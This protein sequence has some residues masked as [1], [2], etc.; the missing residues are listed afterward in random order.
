MTV[1][2]D[3][4][5]R[6]NDRREF[7]ASP[8]PP[9]DPT[10]PGVS[11]DLHKHVNDE[12]APWDTPPARNLHEIPLGRRVVVPPR[13]SVAIRA[14]ARR[15]AAAERGARG[16]V[17]TPIHSVNQPGPAT[18]E[19]AVDGLTAAPDG[20]RPGTG[21]ASRPG[22]DPGSGSRESGGSSTREPGREQVGSGP[23]ECGGEQPGSSGRE[24]PGS[25][26]REPGGSRTGS[27][28]GSGPREHSPTDD[29]GADERDQERRARAARATGY[30]VPC[31]VAGEIRPARYL[32]GDDP[33]CVS[34][35]N[36]RTRPPAA[37][38]APEPPFASNPTNPTP[39]DGRATAGA[40]KAA[41]S[42]RARA[43]QAGPTLSR[44]IKPPKPNGRYRAPNRI[45]RAAAVPDRSRAARDQGEALRSLAALPD[46]QGLPSR[47]RET[48][49][50][51]W[52]ELVRH[53]AWDSLVT[54]PGWKQ[55]CSRAGRSRATV[56]R[57]IRWLRDH[58]LLGLV[59]TGA[60]AAALGTKVARLAAYVLCIPGEVDQL[61]DLAAVDET[62]APPPALSTE[63]EAN[64]TFPQVSEGFETP[65]R[66]PDRLSSPEHAREGGHVAGGTP[67]GVANSK[68]RRQRIVWPKHQTPVKRRDM[69]LAAQTLWHE[70]WLSVGRCSPKLLRHLLK[71]WFAAGWTLADVRHAL[72]HR[73]DGT[74]W[75]YA[76]RPTNQAG[77]LR[78]R[79]QAWVVDGRILPS[80]SQQRSRAA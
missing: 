60:T 10:P 47:S 7:P 51:V 57:A 61:R 34:C 73:P 76:G 8:Q 23:R 35:A 11:A 22:A 30:C 63:D 43:A 56:A 36:V 62:A 4:A 55:L 42:E 41:R 75:R 70:A 44:I 49:A 32:D 68:Q 64:G 40:G 78:W 15:R 39:P 58:G 1:A 20:R 48:I 52:R 79:L 2:H 77:W 13:S 27:R 59:H 31:Y 26:P 37:P 18:A 21:G 24:H 38:D 66:S 25:A 3:C 29:P 9:A 67:D 71:P 14:A 28:T 54:T 74:A 72:D 17:H 65:T 46:W 45:L 33:L 53:A 12:P 69:L 5:V 50:R 6:F 80:L 19:P 16:G